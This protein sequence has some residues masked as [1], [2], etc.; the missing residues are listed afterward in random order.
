MNPTLAN[1]KL[2]Y[3]HYVCFPDDGYRHEIIDGVHYMNAAPSTYHQAVSRRLQY[4]LYSAIE[5]KKLG[6]VIDAPV[7]VHLSEFDIVQ[8]DLVVVLESNRIITP[9]KV[10]GTPDLLVEIL[11]P[12][13]REN[14]MV[15][16]RNR[17]E[18]AGVPEYWIVD[19][20]EHT[21]EQLILTEGS[22]VAREHGDIVTLTILADVSVDL[23]EVW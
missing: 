11:S 5:L 19:P 9:S 10:K 8:P 13:T 20:F 17:Y 23:D 1:H 3:E 18:V 2:R 6:C 15:L 22:Y 16:K 4:Q 7:D 14:D 21:L 12:S